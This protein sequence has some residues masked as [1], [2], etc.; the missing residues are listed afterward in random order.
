MKKFDVYFE[1]FDDHGILDNMDDEP[2]EADH[3]LKEAEIVDLLR[4]RVNENLTDPL[5]VIPVYYAAGADIDEEKPIFA[6]ESVTFYPASYASCFTA[7]EIPHM[8][9]IGEL[10][11]PDTSS[12][13]DTD[14]SAGWH[15][16]G[17]LE[18]EVTA[19]G[20]FGVGMIG[21]EP[22]HPYLASR[23]GGLARRRNIKATAENFVKIFWS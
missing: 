3:I 21:G 18:Y 5:M 4:D 16:Y 11:V 22:V 19:D 8:H 9:F 15:E 14:F 10:E 12:F 2:D 17:C 20:H 7:E 1:W 6:G 13:S 23:F